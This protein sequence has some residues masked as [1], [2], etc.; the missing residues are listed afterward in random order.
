MASAP[1]GSGPERTDD[2]VPDAGLHGPL[3]AVPAALKP[4]D[5]AF[6]KEM[7][8]FGLMAELNGP[9]LVEVAQYVSQRGSL[10]GG[11]V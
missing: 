1:P 8:A 10:V 6:I 7:T 3:A 5:L 2:T 4:Q 9:A 11:N